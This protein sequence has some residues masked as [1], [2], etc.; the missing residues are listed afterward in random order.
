M[1]TIDV[2]RSQACTESGQDFKHLQQMRSVVGRQYTY[3]CATMT[4][5]FDHA[6]R[7]KD[8]QRLAHGT[9]TDVEI[10]RQIRFDQPL[11]DRDFAR[12]DF[13][14]DSARNLIGRAQV[15]Q[16]LSLFRLFFWSM[17]HQPFQPPSPISAGALRYLASSIFPIWLRCT[18]SG[19]SARRSRRAVAYADARP[20]SLFVPPPPKA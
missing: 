6:L 15:S 10:A 18:S 14:G 7:T 1:P 12:Q 4:G 9:A 3:H 16:L 8:T 5:Q 20:K 11:A 13:L 2:G 19:P 17:E